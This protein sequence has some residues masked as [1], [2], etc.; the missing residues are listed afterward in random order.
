[1][2]SKKN[3]G[4]IVI[5]KY[6]L[7]IIRHT[8]A[9]AVLLKCT[10]SFLNRRGTIASED[11]KILM[12]ALRSSAEGH[13]VIDRVLSP[14]KYYYCLFFIL[15]IAAPSVTKVYTMCGP[16]DIDSPFELYIKSFPGF[17]YC[18]HGGT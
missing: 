8:N 1:M 17:I 4:N 13:S 9:C 3:F 16:S 2:T 11:P 6:F 15:Y 18:T 7:S 12:R 14:L 5:G 10:I